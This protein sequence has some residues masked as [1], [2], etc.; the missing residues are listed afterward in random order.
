MLLEDPSAATDVELATELEE[1]G[2]HGNACLGLT[3]CLAC[4][5][6]Q[7]KSCDRYPSDVL[8]IN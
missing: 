4:T 6:E 1:D 3:E 5:T 8:H 2:W 7:T